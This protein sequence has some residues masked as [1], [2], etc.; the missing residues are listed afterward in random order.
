MASKNTIDLAILVSSKSG[1]KEISNKL[2]KTSRDIIKTTPDSLEVTF[3]VQLGRPTKSNQYRL[4]VFLINPGQLSAAIATKKLIDTRLPQYIFLLGKAAGVPDRNIELGDI[5]VPRQIIAYQTSRL[6]V[7]SKSQN[8]VYLT[9]LGLIQSAQS[10]KMGVGKRTKNIKGRVPKIYVDPMASVDGVIGFRPELENILRSW[11]NLT[12]IEMEASGVAATIQG[13]P[14]YEPHLLVIRAVTDLMDEKKVPGEWMSIAIKNAVN[15]LFELLNQALVPPIA[16]LNSIQ[17]AANSAYVDAVKDPLEESSTRTKSRN[18]KENKGNPSVQR[19]GSLRISTVLLENEA[20]TFQIPSYDSDKN[21]E[22]DYLDIEQD[23]E[24]FASLICARSTLPPLSV[25]LFGEWGSGKS[26]FMRKLRSRVEDL[27][28]EARN[29]HKLQKDIAYY[30]RVVQIEFNAWHYAEGNLWASLI[31]H[32]LENLHI[33]GVQPDIIK[34]IQNK[35]LSELVGQKLDEEQA[36][37]DVAEAQNEIKRLEEELKEKRAEYEKVSEKLDTLEA[38]DVLKAVFESSDIQ[39]QFSDVKQNFKDLGFSNLNNNGKDFLSALD[40]LRQIIRR[41]NTI[42]VPFVNSPQRTKWIV[43]FLILIALAP[44]AGLVVGWAMQKIG[45]QWVSQYSA[46]I[47]AIAGWISV[48]TETIR[49]SA[50]WVSDR[51]TPIERLKQSINNEVVVQQNLINEKIA[52]LEK[53]R[54]TLEQGKESALRRLDDVRR[55][56]EITEDELKQATP[57]RLLAKFI[58]KRVESNDYRKHLGVLALVRDDFERLSYFIEHENQECENFETLDQELADADNRINRIVLYIDDL[59]R[60]STEKVVQVL[61]AVHL[62]LAFPLFVVVVAVDARWVSGALYE[63]YKNMLKPK[64]ILNNGLG[65]ENSIIGATALDYLEKIFQIPFW[66]SPMNLAA[67]KAMIDGLVKVNTVEEIKDNSAK[68]GDLDSSELRDLDTKTLTEL[69]NVLDQDKEATTQPQDNVEQPPIKPKLPLPG[70]DLN[71]SALTISLAEQDFINQL[72]PLLGRSPRALKRFINVYRLIKSSVPE[73]VQSRFLSKANGEFRVAM[74][75]LAIVTHTPE[76]SQEFLEAL[77]KF[78]Q[79]KPK[80]NRLKAA[81]WNI[82]FGA[83]DKTT[84]T[85]EQNQLVNW[86]RTKDAKPIRDVNL[87]RLIW[88]ARRACRFSFLLEPAVAEWLTIENL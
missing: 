46:W 20:F 3:P 48:I 33:K 17:L 79:E 54:S 78:K 52:E 29:A 74:F 16:L 56:K 69:N 77:H 84:L 47:T 87:K 85:S 39:T 82:L 50:K 13:I 55:N 72:S 70:T 53:R 34:N 86:I 36:K 51:I 15:F 6:K 71:P 75:L 19:K 73:E 10:L 32:I 42:L 11:P 14:G 7:E 18:E 62:L 80:T 4:S 24:A 83:V 23:V 35:L 41:G 58:E 61:E 22:E 27:S 9:D 67:R 57:S 68:L 45:N 12:G 5:L 49:T 1:F 63:Q 2:S 37:K 76:F 59:D 88:W 66:L 81:D 40:E 26:F 30:K 31:E 43:R 21:G 25:G 65:K 64:Q 28:F 38:K 8:D 60:C 44:L